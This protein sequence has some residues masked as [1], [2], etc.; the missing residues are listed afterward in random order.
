MLKSV[1]QKFVTMMLIGM[2]SGVTLAAPKERLAINK[3]GIKVWTIQLADNPMAKYRAETVF[4][5]TLA[6]AVGL[7]L[8]TEY[9]TQW[10]PNVGEIKILERNDT[11]GSFIAYMVI[12]MPFPLANRDLVI[13]GDIY[14]DSEGKIIVKNNATKDSRAPEKSGV[15]RITEYEGDWT[16]QKVSDK[17]V[18]VSSQ[19]YADPSGAVPKGIVNSFVQQQPY[20][21]FQKMRNQL[22][23]EKYTL[24]D[25]PKSVQ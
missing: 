22:K 17:Q 12:S 25:L 15:V 7:I 11:T 10:M 4:D 24:K 13:K 5:T 2:I 14:K 23:T 1:K 19:G 20:Q 6:N 18:K 21:M 3:Q 9:S 16:F 8:D